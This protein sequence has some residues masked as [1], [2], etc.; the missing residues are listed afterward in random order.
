M[1][2]SDVLNM[3]GFTIQDCIDVV[4]KTPVEITIRISPEEQELN[5]TPWRPFTYTCPKQVMR[6]ET[7]GEADESD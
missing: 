6:T 1:N 7:E 3:N 2:L 4:G 5:I